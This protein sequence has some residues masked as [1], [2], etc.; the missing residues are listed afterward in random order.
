VSQGADSNRNGADLQLK[1]AVPNL[2]S[3]DGGNHAKAS[4][5][6]DG[7]GL[8]RKEHKNKARIFNREIHQ[9]HEKNFRNPFVFFVI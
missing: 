5:T 4:L 8:N 2:G 3:A 7:H 1:T 6:T 9:R